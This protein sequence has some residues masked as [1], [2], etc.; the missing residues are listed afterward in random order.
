MLSLSQEKD[1]VNSIISSGVQEILYEGLRIDGNNLG[2]L[3]DEMNLFMK[4]LQHK[5]IV[6]DFAV[7]LSYDSLFSR[8]EGKIAY[9]LINSEEPQFQD[10]VQF[11]F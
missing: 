7:M 8:F 10:L 2:Y 9:S 4:A 3:E 6:Y 5:N 1:W 11:K